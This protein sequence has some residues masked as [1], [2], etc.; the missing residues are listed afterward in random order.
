MENASKALIMAAE[1]LIGVM[2]ISVG[3]YIFNEMGKYS[4]DTTA[5]MEETQ[6][7]QF[8]NQFLKYYGT[9]GEDENGKPE[10]I[11][12]TI[13]NI[14]GLANLARKT[15]I[16]NG[17]VDE[18]GEPVQEEPSDNSFYIRIDVKIGTKNYNHLE[19]K[20]QSELIE[21]IKNND[22]EHISPDENSED[23]TRTKYFKALEPGI[24]EYTKRVNIMKFVE[25]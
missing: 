6:I 25:I 15:N 17:F 8:N 14:V 11:K 10:T 16:Q 22:I 19:C 7:A 9:S 13:H 24:G 12:C 20:S 1:I 18:N 4:A 3:V 2:I 23:K 5:E 21:I